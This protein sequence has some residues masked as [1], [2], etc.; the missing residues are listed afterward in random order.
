MK[1]ANKRYAVVDKVTPEIALYF[2]NVFA[3]DGSIYSVFPTANQ[4]YLPNIGR[5]VP[6]LTLKTNETAELII[7][8]LKK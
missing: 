5:E 7:G 1:Y 2:D 6:N 3:L 4:L 8:F